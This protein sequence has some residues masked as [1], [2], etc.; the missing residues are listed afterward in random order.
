MYIYIYTYIL[1]TIKID[2]CGGNSEN[3]M[4]HVAHCVHLIIHCQYLYDYIN[5][6]K[7]VKI[8]MEYHINLPSI[9]MYI[10]IL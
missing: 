6:K 1:N 3:N 5:I 2:L 8:Y 10:Y 4:Y 9:Y 7:H